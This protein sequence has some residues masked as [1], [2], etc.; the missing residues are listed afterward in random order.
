MENGQIENL[1]ANHSNIDVSDDTKPTTA[2]GSSTR[3]VV[4]PSPIITANPVQKPSRANKH[5]Q[6]K[7]ISKYHRN[8]LSI[9][10]W[11]LF[12]GASTFAIIIPAML[13]GWQYLQFGR[14]YGQTAA[15]QH[16][17]YW[18]VLSMVLLGLFMVAL[19]TQLRKSI[20]VLKV[21]TDGIYFRT[22]Y[23]YSGYCLYNQIR[24]LSE[25]CVQE[26]FLGIKWRLQTHHLDY[27][28]KWKADK[29]N[30]K[31]RQSLTFL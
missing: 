21:Y 2:P 5:S 9:M 8:R 25:D 15:K 3:P 11:L 1:T 26:Q 14:V 7:I 18:A 24:G 22:G 13:A 29:I 23:F 4:V 31:F 6:H 27:K 20:S 10:G 28:V 17:I 16:S 12:L 19:V 30:L